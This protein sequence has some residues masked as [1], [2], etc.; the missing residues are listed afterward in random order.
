MHTHNK[1]KKFTKLA[2]I[3]AAIS[4]TALQAEAKQGDWSLRLAPGVSFT[5][6]GVPNVIVKGSEVKVGSKFKVGFNGSGSILYDI[7]DHFGFNLGIDIG[8][9]GQ[10]KIAVSS[11]DNSGVMDSTASFYN[12]RVLAGIHGSYPMSDNLSMFAI[13]GAGIQRTSLNFELNAK[14][15]SQEL[16]AAA[17][18]SGMGFA[19]QAGI[20]LMYKIS[21][22]VYIDCGYTL[23]YAKTNIKG[24]VSE[25]NIPIMPK[26]DQEEKMHHESLYQH[27]IQVGLRYTF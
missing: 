24:K 16:K 11:T 20:G 3:C 9:I 1:Q 2:I 27:N 26:S 14:K 21:D 5:N 19:G 15:D 8:K 25:S 23:S 6:L 17:N 18:G 22:S 12:Q 4:L 13:L 7:Q 10:L